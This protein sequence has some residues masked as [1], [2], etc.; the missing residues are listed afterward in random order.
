MKARE[1]VRKYL[2][3][4][5]AVLHKKDGDHHIFRLPSGRTLI[6]PMG[7]SQTEVASYLV[8]KF[9]RLMRETK[10]EASRV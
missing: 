5:G 10:P 9:H 2:I 8:S 7:G 6:V 3:P 4:A 1:F